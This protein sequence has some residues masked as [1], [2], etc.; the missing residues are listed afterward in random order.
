MKQYGPY[1]VDD[2]GRILLPAEVR[3]A[4]GLDSKTKVIFDVRDDGTIALTPVKNAQVASGNGC[5]PQP[6]M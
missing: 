2:F 1:T 3:Q 5:G 4:L 6:P